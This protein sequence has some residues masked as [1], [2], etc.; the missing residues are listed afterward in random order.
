MSSINFELENMR[1][2]AEAEARKSFITYII[3]T[4]TKKA[5]PELTRKTFCLFMGDVYL[6]NNHI[7]RESPTTRFLKHLI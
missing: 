4:K 5:S 1:D 3:R 2:K 6:R 7:I